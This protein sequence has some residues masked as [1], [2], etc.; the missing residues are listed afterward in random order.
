MK[1]E[2]IAYPVLTVQM[3]IAVLMWYYSLAAPSGYETVWAVLLFIELILMSLL[4][5][6]FIR[7]SEAFRK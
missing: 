4:I 7:T 6:L 3:V 1:I 2:T 5:L